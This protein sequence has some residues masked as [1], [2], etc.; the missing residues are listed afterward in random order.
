MRCMIQQRQRRSAMKNVLAAG[1]ISD[2][3]HQ[4]QQDSS[5]APQ[6]CSQKHTQQLD[7]NF[8]LSPSMEQSKMR[9]VLCA[10]A[11]S[12]AI[13]HAQSTAGI[14][15]PW[16]R[17]VASLTKLPAVLKIQHAQKRERLP[18]CRHGCV[19]HRECGLHKV[20]EGRVDVVEDVMTMLHIPEELWCQHLQTG[21]L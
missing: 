5:R 8:L 21:R 4:D 11:W 7:C 12:I 9:K 19:T 3:S 18:S 16:A 13:D 1:P 2:I 6:D 17:L 10:A 15:K 20:P 14:L